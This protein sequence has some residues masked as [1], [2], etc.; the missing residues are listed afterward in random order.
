MVRGGSRANS[1]KTNDQDKVEK[2]SCFQNSEKLYQASHNTSQDRD[3]RKENQTYDRYTEHTTGYTSHRDRYSD[4]EGRYHQEFNH[5]GHGKKSAREIRYEI[6]VKKRGKLAHIFIC[7]LLA[8]MSKYQI[9]CSNR[10][11]FL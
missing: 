7:W 11:F 2:K 5:R 10:I 9:I 4:R 3:K 8:L 6:Q 1:Q